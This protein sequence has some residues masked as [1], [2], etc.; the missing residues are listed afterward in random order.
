MCEPADPHYIHAG[1]FAKV[2]EKEATPKSSLELDFDHM[3]GPATRES[4]EEHYFEQIDVASISPQASVRPRSRRPSIEAIKRRFSL[5]R[6]TS[7]TST[8]ISTENRPQGRSIF[9]RTFSR[10]LTAASA[11]DSEE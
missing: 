2:M 7:T 4:S 1:K 5:K 3:F 10:K 8:T 6:N 9:Q 11:S